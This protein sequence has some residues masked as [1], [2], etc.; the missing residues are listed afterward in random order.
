MIGTTC[1]GDNAARANDFS[2]DFQNWG[3]K[4]KSE[5]SPD[6]KLSPDIFLNNYWKIK[7]FFLEFFIHISKISQ[8]KFI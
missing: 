5:Y 3:L 4:K 7:I 6:F 1:S 2:L 8:K